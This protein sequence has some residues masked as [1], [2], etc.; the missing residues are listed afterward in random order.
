LP[1]PPAS[2]NYC[3]TVE[4]ATYTRFVFN[5]LCAN[6][7]ITALKSVADRLGTEKRAPCPCRK[8]RPTKKHLH[9]GVILSLD[10]GVVVSERWRV[11]NFPGG[12]FGRP[13]AS[14]TSGGIAGQE[15]Q[16]EVSLTLR[17]SSVSP[18][19]QFSET[20]IGLQR[21]QAGIDANE[22][23]T[24]RMLPFSLREPAKR[25]VGFSN[26]GVDDRDLIS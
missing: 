11:K 13:E 3:R 10:R 16:T 17:D 26:R 8:C 23:E 12:L 22:G 21:F 19:Y 7:Q 6:A 2:R 5:Y 18:V 25:V 9:F 15:L 14:S 1:P 24:H 4:I 20:G